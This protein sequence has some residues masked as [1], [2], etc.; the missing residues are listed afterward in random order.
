MIDYVT[1]YALTQ[2]IY[3]IEAQT[4]SSPKLVVNAKNKIEYYHKPFWHTTKAE[5]V[6]HAEQMRQRKIVSVE[7]QLAKLKALTFEE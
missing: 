2:G 6:A 1:K 4:T 3:Q 5:A 7:K